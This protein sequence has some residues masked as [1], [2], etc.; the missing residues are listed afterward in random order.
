MNRITATLVPMFV[1]IA[2]LAGSPVGDAVGAT[3]STKKSTIS[4]TKSATASKPGKAKP[5]A[6]AKPGSK[7]PS[8]SAKRSARSRGNQRVTASKPQVVVAA[9]PVVVPTVNPAAVA[10]DLQPLVKDAGEW[11]DTVGASPQM[12]GLAMAIVKDNDIVF[13]KG[14]GVVEK[15]TNTPIGTNTVFRLASLSKAFA[16]TLAGLLVRDGVIE[17]DTRIVSLL[18][19]FALA[20]TAGESLTVRDIMSQRAGLPHNAFDRDLEG[21]A[22]YP[23]LVDKLRSVPLA[24][25]VGDC[26]AYQNIAFSLIGDVTYAAT[27]DFFYYQVEKRLFHPLHMDTAT[28]GREALEAS[29]SWARPHVRSGGGWRAVAPKDNYYRVPPAAGVNASINDMAQWLIAQMGG[30]PDVLPATLLDELHKP[31]VDTPRELRASPWR[32]GRLTDAHYGLGWRVFDYAGETMIYHAG[33]VQGY[34]GMIAFLPK[35]RF[36]MVMLWNNEAALPSGLM[37]MVMD[38]YL[39]LPTVNWA[40]IDADDTDIASTGD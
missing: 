23:M 38:R 22:P 19:T 21:D 39:G 20:D 9:E 1:G 10:H 3:K 16:S 12:A 11:V 13:E 32:R 33:A 15:G 29:A 26:Y 18:P 4:T 40:G 14:V 34:R 30:R 35:Y 8:A 6:K 25:P 5:G 31:L 24:C 17:W 36:G 28:Y 2:L 27:G 7:T 37:P